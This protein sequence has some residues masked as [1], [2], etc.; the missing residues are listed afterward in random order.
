MERVRR[1]GLQI[2][3]TSQLRGGQ[4]VFGW[5]H[6][7]VRLLPGRPSLY[8]AVRRPAARSAPLTRW[9]RVAVLAAAGLLLP[10]AVVAVL[11]ETAARRG[12]PCTWRPAVRK[13]QWL[14]V[15]RPATDH[16]T[17]VVDGTRQTC[18]PLWKRSG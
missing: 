15:S 4:V 8:D 18:T 1:E 10:V 3:R 2:V 13:A 17:A 5:L 11:V 7:F 12:G 6:G 9:Q 14:G 16:M